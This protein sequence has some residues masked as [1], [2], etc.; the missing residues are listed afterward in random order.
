MSTLEVLQTC[1]T[2]RKNF[3][4]AL[5]AMDPENSNIITFKL[6]DFKRRLSHQLAFHI[7]TK[8]DGNTI[9]RTVLD[10]GSSTL[11]MSLSCWRAIG[12]PEINH[13]PSTLKDFYGH[14]FQPYGLLP[15]IHVQLGAS[16]S[17][18]ISKSLT[19]LWITT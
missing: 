10:E 11:V 8:I 5:G 19:L 16:Y 7:A 18:F 6:D 14:G 1:P 13:L 3:V 17:P 2:Q 12:S 4:T 15:V 9:R